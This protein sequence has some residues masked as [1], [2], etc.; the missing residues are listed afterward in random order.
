M[1]VERIYA[2]GFC[3]TSHGFRPGRSGHQ[4]LS[5]LGQ[6]IATRKVN[7]ILDADLRGFFDNVFHERMVELL[8]Q[9]I[10]DPQMLALADS[11]RRSPP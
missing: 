1:I 4:A 5:V 10:A 9:R 2:A 3:D 8:R 6:I 7:W 11:G